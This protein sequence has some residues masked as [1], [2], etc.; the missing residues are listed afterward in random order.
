MSFEA[1]TKVSEATKLLVEQ[2]FSD[3]AVQGALELVGRA[4]G[5]D[6]ALVLENGSG[7]TAAQRLALVRHGWSAAPLDGLWRAPLAVEQHAPGWVDVLSR[8]HAMWELVKDVPRSMQGVLGGQKVQSLALCPILVGGR[9]WGFLRLD[10]CQ[11]ARRWSTEEVAVVKMLGNS[12]GSAVNRDRR[13]A[14]LLQTRSELQVLVNRCA[15][16]VAGT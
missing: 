10:D 3:R 5:V 16:Q 12:L 9:W 15:A 6:R 14:A 1:F 4:L 11:K 2:G 7:A 8:G 13:R